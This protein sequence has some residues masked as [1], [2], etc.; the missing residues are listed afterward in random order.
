MPAR[1]RQR[2]PSVTD[3][4]PNSKRTDS[5]PEESSKKSSAPESVENRKIK[6]LLRECSWWQRNFIADTERVLSVWEDRHGRL[7]PYIDLQLKKNE[8]RLHVKKLVSEQMKKYK[9]ELSGLKIQNVLASSNVKEMKDQEEKLEMVHK[10]VSK[11]KKCSVQ[12]SD[13]IEIIELRP[14]EPYKEELEAALQKIPTFASYESE[15]NNLPKLKKGDLDRILWPEKIFDLSPYSIHWE[16][17]FEEAAECRLLDEK[18]K[19]CEQSEQQALSE[20]KL[21]RTR[22]VMIE[23]TDKHR[24]KKK[25]RSQASIFWEP[26]GT[27]DP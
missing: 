5:A 21:V 22:Q 12:D 11:F 10:E 18:L 15:I 6:S 26:T 7:R 16:T 14:Y 4:N 17:D 9:K 3:Y 23:L 20:Y 27:A 2:E 13:D 19:N 8:D 1:K 25:Q 24:N